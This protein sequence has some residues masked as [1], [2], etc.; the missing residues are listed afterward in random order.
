MTLNA[1]DQKILDS[2]E[3][4]KW[5]SIENVTEEM[6][7]YRSYAA[8]QLSKSVKIVLSDEDYNR[9]TRLAGGSG[10]SSEELSREILHKFLN[11][12][13]IKKTA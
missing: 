6:T 8:N 12:E 3:A 10:K 2:L 13:L 11:G 7:R 4:E 9:L 5:Q 1:E